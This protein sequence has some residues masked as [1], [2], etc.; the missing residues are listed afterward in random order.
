MR[1]S[2]SVQRHDLSAGGSWP[3]PEDTGRDGT[4]TDIGRN[5]A[6]R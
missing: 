5:E 6:A 3:P 1:G 4:R 2:S